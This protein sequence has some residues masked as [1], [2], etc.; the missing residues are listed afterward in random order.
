[1]QPLPTPCP[2]DLVPDAT[3]VDVFYAAYKQAKRQHAA[4]IAVERIDRAPRPRHA[5]ASLRSSGRVLLPLVDQEPWRQARR[6]ENLQAASTRRQ[7]S[8]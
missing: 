1:M 6:Y 3:A 4:F 5:V 2:A 8:D 7:A